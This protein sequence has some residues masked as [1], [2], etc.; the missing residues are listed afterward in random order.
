MNRFAAAT[1]AGLCLGA[2]SAEAAG[3][4]A[5]IPAPPN[6][7][8]LGS[9]TLSSGG[10]EA[11]YSTAANASD[12]ITSYKA[13]LTAAGWTVTGSGG[14]GSEHGGGAGL[15]A[16]NGP[17]HLVIDAGGPAGTT[18]VHVCVWPAKPNDD[19]CGD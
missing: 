16:T 10:E 7:K 18:F 19:H 1:L 15:Q 17:R 2:L 4:L 14:S 12:V 13:A 3:L 11:S 8:T 5:D 9:S 6:A